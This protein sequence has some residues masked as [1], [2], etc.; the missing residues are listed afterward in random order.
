MNFTYDF[1]NGT[2]EI[3]YHPEKKRIPDP[4]ML[5]KINRCVYLL[6]IKVRPGNEG[7]FAYNIKGKTNFLAWQSE[8][9]EKA[10]MGIPSESVV[11]EKRYMYVDDRTQRIN[12]ICI[13][14]MEDKPAKAAKKN[15]ENIYELETPPLPDTIPEPRSEEIYE[16][17]GNNHVNQTEER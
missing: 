7:A 6:N 8:A 14:G 13:P 5:E 10:R 4:E 15:Q 3:V 2:T 9:S 17:F 12:F 1:A 11:Q 16:P